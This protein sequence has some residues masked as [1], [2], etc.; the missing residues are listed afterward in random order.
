MSATSIDEGRLEAFMGL[1]LP[2]QQALALA[3]EDS[4]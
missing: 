2:D 4:P 3:D 1:T